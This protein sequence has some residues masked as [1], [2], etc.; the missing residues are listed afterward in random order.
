LTA[1]L[2]RTPCFSQSRT[3]ANPRRRDG[4][5]LC[6]GPEPGFGRSRHGSRQSVWVFSPRGHFALKTRFSSLGFSWISLDSLVRI[7]TYQR[8]IWPKAH[9]SSFG[10]PPVRLR[11]FGRG[12]LQPRHGSAQECSR[13]R[14]NLPSDV[15]QGIVV[16]ALPSACLNPNATR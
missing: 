14:F 16:R 7:E 11:A 12:A 1:C 9:N 5:T 10:A 3:S 4:R 6:T 13:S 8:V 2:R 15:P